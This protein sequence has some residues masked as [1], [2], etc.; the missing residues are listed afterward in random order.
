MGYLIKWDET[1]LSKLIKNLYSVKLKVTY[2][3]AE[4]TLLALA[5]VKGSY[6]GLQWASRPAPLCMVPSYHV[7]PKYTFVSRAKPKFTDS[8]YKA[9]SMLRFS[10]PG[11]EGR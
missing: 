11:R 10:F 2:E 9:E 7:S 1:G 5:E 4:K 8:W 6:E 3:K